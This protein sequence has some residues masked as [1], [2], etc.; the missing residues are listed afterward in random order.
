MNLLTQSSPW[1][2]GNLTKNIWAGILH[3]STILGAQLFTGSHMNLKGLKK[4]L[5]KSYE[6]EL[7][8]I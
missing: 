1:S 2:L 5:L 3:N 4:V 6:D 8:F 7:D